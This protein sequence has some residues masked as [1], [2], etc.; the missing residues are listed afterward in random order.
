[1][2]YRIWNFQFQYLLV[3]R[4]YQV[5]K[6]LT[7]TFQDENLHASQS[8]HFLA[9]TKVGL[10]GAAILTQM[11]RTINWKK[12]NLLN[13]IKQTLAKPKLSLRWWNA[14][15]QIIEVNPLKFQ[16]FLKACLK[17]VL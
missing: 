5:E 6:D 1:M 14:T 11:N 12:N 17:H 4:I 3:W 8:R 13:K 15:I 2:L 10:D 7:K 9:N 16:E